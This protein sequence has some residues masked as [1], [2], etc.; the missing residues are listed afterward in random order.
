[1]I[2]RSEKIEEQIVES[3]AE[4]RKL[5]KTLYYDLL[6]FE[7]WMNTDKT[8]LMAWTKA[9]MCICSRHASSRGV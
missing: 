6:K 7:L 9:V 3:E 8:K 5:T 4:A 2:T 1:M